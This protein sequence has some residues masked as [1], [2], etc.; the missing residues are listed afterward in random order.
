M[1]SGPIS[2]NGLDDARL[3]GPS[4]PRREPE[5]RNYPVTR[6]TTPDSGSDAIVGPASCRSF[7]DEKAPTGPTDLF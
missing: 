2:Q 5:N 1:R 6:G 7:D 3:H 4:H